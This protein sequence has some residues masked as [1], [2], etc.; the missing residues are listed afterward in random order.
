MASQSSSKRRRLQID[1]ATNT[2]V[3]QQVKI[4]REKV[5]EL[6]EQILQE[7]R[8][9]D[10]IDKVD[11]LRVKYLAENPQIAD[12]M[13]TLKQYKKNEE[14]LEKVNDSLTTCENK[15]FKCIETIEH[16][17]LKLHQ[18]LDKIKKENGHSAGRN[19]EKPNLNV[20]ELVGFAGRLSQ[21]IA[22]QVPA[23]QPIVHLNNFTCSLY[24]Q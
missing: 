16:S 20:D 19:T 6:R 14:E 7:I 24:N 10:G 3:G 4:Q 11:A 9:N 8:R 23:P 1:D 21:F 17:E 13:K 18:L 2:N 22:P 12:L 5:Q 15:Y